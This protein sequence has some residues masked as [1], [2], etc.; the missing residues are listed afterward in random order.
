M[1][2]MRSNNLHFLLNARSRWRVLLLPILLLGGLPPCVFAQGGDSD[3]SPVAASADQFT[4]YKV[5]DSQRN[6]LNKINGILRKGK[7]D[8]DAQK[9]EFDTFYKT[10]ALARWTQ[11]GQKKTNNLAQLP[12]FRTELTNQ[13]RQARS[14]EVHDHLNDLAL[15]YLEKTAKDNCHPTVRVNAMLMI[16]SLN[17]VEGSQ[18]KALESALP[19]LLSAVDDK[20]QIAPVKIA[21]LVGINHHVAQGVNNPQMQNRILA[22]MLGLVAS[23]P[24]DSE[25]A[26]RQWMRMQAVDILG[27]LGMPG[28]NNQVVQ[29]L[30]AVVGDEKAKLSL[31]CAAAEALGKINIAPTGNVNAVALAKPL[32][33]L[34]AQGCGA[35]LKSVDELGMPAFRRSMKACLQSVMEGLKRLTPLANNPPQQAYLKE[36]Q[37]TF[38]GLLKDLDDS[39]LEDPEVQK[40]VEETQA[41]LNEWVAKKP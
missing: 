22:T 2:R 20:Q 14:G 8:D 38:D 18:T 17:A 37:K 12:T 35:A 40:R 34:M 3:E 6:N 23:D 16:G 10:Y 25:D 27:L 28:N 30:S 21:A 7:F 29:A 11:I 15:Q 32:G 9:A 33:Q 24:A 4:E 41:K 13:L 39:K 31:R 26:G 36:L 5:D 19:V 1:L